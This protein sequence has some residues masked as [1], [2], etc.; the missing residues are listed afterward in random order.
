MS[1]RNLF[2]I[3]LVLI[4]NCEGSGLTPKYTDY[5][6]VKSKQTAAKIIGTTQYEIYKLG[7]PERKRSIQ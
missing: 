2:K 3:L 7:L 1:L 6:K 4:K 5:Q